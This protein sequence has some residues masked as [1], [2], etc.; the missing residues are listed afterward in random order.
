[1]M[2]KESTKF[3]K[4]RKKRNQIFNIFNSK[5]GTYMLTDAIN[6]NIDNKYL[7]FIEIGKSA[8]YFK[9]NKKFRERN[10][11]S[12]VQFHKDYLSNFMSNILEKLDVDITPQDLDIIME[13]YVEDNK[14]TI[15]FPIG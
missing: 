1:M 11:E 5:E 14:I 2:N 8:I 10:E 3:I 15:E 13:L 12:P 6:K 4:L 9:A 7:K